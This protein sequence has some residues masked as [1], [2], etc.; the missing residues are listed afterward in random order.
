MESFGDFLERRKLN[1][2]TVSPQNTDKTADL[3]ISY[4]NKK[5]GKHYN[6]VDVLDA[7]KGSNKIKQAL[8]KDADGSAVGVNFT[9][10]GEFLSISVWN[11][12]RLTGVGGWSQPDKDIVFKSQESFATALPAAIDALVNRTDESAINEVINTYKYNGTTYNGK[13]EVA[14]AMKKDGLSDLQI[15]T[16]LKVPASKLRKLLGSEEEAGEDGSFEIKVAEPQKFN[17]S[18][19]VSDAVEKFEETEYA[20]PEIVFKQMDTMVKSV[21]QGINAAL[22]ITGQGGIG[23]SFGVG[24]VLK[25]VLG[26][27]K[28]EDYVIMKGST[29]TYAMY[30]FIYNNYN[31][32]IIFDDCDSVFDG[33][34]SLNILKA[35]LDSGE[36]RIVSWD[37]AGTVPV[38]A[39][40]SH[41]ELEQML[42]EYS[43][44]HHNK[45]AVPSQ[46]E[47]E[48]GI[49][50]ISNLSKDAIAK[51]DAALLSRCMNIDVTFSLEDTINRIK[52]CLPYIKYY[53][54][55]KINGQSVDI[56]N[57]ED[58]AEVMEYM[59]S[60]DFKNILKKTHNAKVSFRTLINLCKLKASDPENWKSCV[61]RAI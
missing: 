29:S 5:L 26:L 33:A 34:D 9:T 59:L 41:E 28:G 47:F 6:I 46:F 20:D 18:P 37:T 4:F 56:T 55:K 16:S 8:Y 21:G 1:E 31:K 44:A 58:K 49:I 2:A 40:I 19:E 30:R 27:V 7:I 57:E 13:R 32:V 22:L 53:A 52:T 61:D 17:E 50:F 54:A 39:G 10:S 42:A 43:A 48:G 12:L 60:T 51:K 25:E 23:K 14:Q 11:T 45:P 35:V 24:R 36:E 15:M 3:I 38:P